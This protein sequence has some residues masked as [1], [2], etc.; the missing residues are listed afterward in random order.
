MPEFDAVGLIKPWGGG[1]SWRGHLWDLKRGRGS[2]YPLQSRTRA[3]SGQVFCPT[4]LP[5]GRT[6]KPAGTRSSRT[7][8]GPLTRELILQRPDPARPNIWAGEATPSSSSVGSWPSAVIRPLR[9][10]LSA[11]SRSRVHTVGGVTVPP[12]I[13]LAAILALPLPPSNTSVTR[14]GRGQLR[15][16]TVGGVLLSRDLRLSSRLRCF[17]L[18]RSG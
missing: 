2:T 13:R 1:V 5:T 9:S 17:V 15:F 12:G 14:T 3:D 18:G 6:E 11:A 7:G 8:V 4:R 10:L 16:Q